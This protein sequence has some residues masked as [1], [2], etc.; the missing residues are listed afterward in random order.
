MVE[1]MHLHHLHPT[2]YMG[3]QILWTVENHPLL[4]P[5]HQLDHPLLP[6]QW[7]MDIGTLSL[8][9]GLIWVS[10]KI[11]LSGLIVALIGFFDI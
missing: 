3:L 10:K 9:L 6:H 8:Q 7:E 1:E 2:E 4:L 11:Y 5:E